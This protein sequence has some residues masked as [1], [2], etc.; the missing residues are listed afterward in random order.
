MVRHIEWQVHMI[1]QNV[2]CAPDL[3][4]T[5]F[6]NA[7]MTTFAYAREIILRCLAY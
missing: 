2:S 7:Y 1:S 4:V 5:T 3:Y 6:V